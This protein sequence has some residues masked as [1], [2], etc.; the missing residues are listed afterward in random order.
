MELTYTQKD[1][2]AIIGNLESALEDLKDWSEKNEDK[3]RYEV[4]NI[5][6]EINNL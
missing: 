4:D 2:K 5:Q 1:L 6:N 3:Y